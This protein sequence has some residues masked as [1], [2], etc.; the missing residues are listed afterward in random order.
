M[1]EDE[2]K[3]EE[4]REMRTREKGGWMGNDPRIGQHLNFVDSSEDRARSIGADRSRREVILVV[5]FK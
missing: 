4:K 1:D 5:E 3:E 2:K